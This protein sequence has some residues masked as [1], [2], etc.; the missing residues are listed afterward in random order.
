M[1]S[2]ILAALAAF[3]LGALATNAAADPFHHRH[4]HY[5]HHHR[6]CR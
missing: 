1:K 4:C 3:T 6:Y 5:H 2:M